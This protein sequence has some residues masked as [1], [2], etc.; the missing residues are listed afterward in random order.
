MDSIWLKY[1]TTKLDWDQTLIIIFLVWATQLITWGAKKGYDS[2]EEWRS[3]NL[4]DQTVM[5]RL[6]SI[7]SPQILDFLKTHDLSVA[8]N[9]KILDPIG[10]ALYYNRFENPDLKFHDQKLEKLRA[11]LMGSIM[12]F[13]DAYLADVSCVETNVELLRVHKLDRQFDPDGRKYVVMIERI[14]SLA[15]DIVKKFE[16]LVAATNR[17]FDKKL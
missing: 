13:W 14:N 3:P 12:A 7:F 11:Q 17:A 5:G 6:R 9:S 10:E 15:S 2:F 16:A 8:F 4:H 1:V